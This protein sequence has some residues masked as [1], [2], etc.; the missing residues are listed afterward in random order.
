VSGGRDQPQGVPDV[1]SAVRFDQLGQA[2]PG[3][4][5]TPIAAAAFLC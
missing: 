3:R 1:N 5:G 2:L 4:I